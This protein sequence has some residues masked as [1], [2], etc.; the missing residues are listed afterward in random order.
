MPYSPNVTVDIDIYKSGTNTHPSGLKEVAFAISDLDESND[1]FYYTGNDML[2]VYVNKNYSNTILAGYNGGNY[3]FTDLNPVKLESGE[4]VYVYAAAHSNYSDGTILTNPGTVILQST[5]MQNGHIT[6]TSYMNNMGA[7][8]LELSGLVFIGGAAQIIYRDVT[9]PSSPVTL[10]TTTVIGDVGETINYDPT[11]KINE[12][13]QRNYV[14]VANPFPTSEKYTEAEKT[15]YVDLRIAPKSK[16]LVIYKDITDNV[17]L[18]RTNVMEG[19]VNTT[20][21]YNPQ[22]KITSYE[23]IGYELVSNP[24]TSTQKYPATEGETKTITITFKHATPT[25][26]DDDLT[27]KTVKR[28][29]HYVYDDGHLPVPAPD[30]QQDAL[31][32]RI[33]RQ[34]QI[35]QEYFYED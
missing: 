9:N 18:E 26:V 13:A 32:T 21:N 5:G 20:I 7:S 14:V 6:L 30:K 22:S 3:Y 19:E 4:D 34:D 10:Y 28:I 8:H 24:F 15:F 25:I 31:F 23:N 2:H 29:I 27:K 17:E 12:Y 35:T 33:V 16:A 11:S 1:G